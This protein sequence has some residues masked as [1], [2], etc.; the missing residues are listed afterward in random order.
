KSDLKEEGYE[1]RITIK[2]ERSRMGSMRI[3][4]E[5]NGIGIRAEDQEKIFTPFFTTKL[6][7]KKGTGLGL[8]VIQKL[9]EENHKG[10]VFY[11]S[12][13][14]KGTRVY[15]TLPTVEGL[16]QDMI[17]SVERQA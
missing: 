4:L 10:K 14:G 15:I 7:S 8:Y 11:K 13:Y 9:I 12:E 3:V 16:D 2:A 1:P 6:S 17:Q 5:D